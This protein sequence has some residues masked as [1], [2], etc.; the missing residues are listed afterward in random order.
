MQN[1]VLPGLKSL[2]KQKSNSSKLKPTRPAVEYQEKQFNSA[3]QFTT[4]Q[5]KDNS[6]GCPHSPVMIAFINQKVL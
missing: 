3:N 1:W 5:A 2:I 4:E 6:S